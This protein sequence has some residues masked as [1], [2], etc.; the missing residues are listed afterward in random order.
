MFAK[1]ISIMVGVIFLLTAIAIGIFV[2][3]FPAMLR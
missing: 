2:F 3:F 1:S